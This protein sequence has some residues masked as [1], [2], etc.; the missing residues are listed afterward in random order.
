MKNNMNVRQTVLMGTIFLLLLSACGKNGAVKNRSRSLASGVVF[1]SMNLDQHPTDRVVIKLRSGK[2]LT[3][4]NLVQQQNSG[5]QILQLDRKMNADGMQKTINQLK[6]DPAV[7]DVEPDYI[8]QT[9][10]EPNDT[11][12]SGAFFGN[13]HPLK[14]FYTPNFQP[15]FDYTKG[16]ANLP[17]AWDITEGSQNIVIAVID[18]GKLD[19][20]DLVGHFVNGYDFISS[21][22]DPGDLGAGSFWHGTMVA[23]VVGA[24]GN[25][26]NG[27]VGVNLN[28]RIMPIRVC[29]GN[30]CSTAS[31]A[32]GIRWAVEHG[33]RVVNIS[34]GGIGACPN[35]LQN[36]IDYAYTHNTVV[37]AS[38][39]N[40]GQD[41]DF[42]PANCN[43]VISVG[44]NNWYGE[45]SPYSNYGSR[46]DISAPGDALLM[47]SNPGTQ[48]PVAYQAQEQQGDY[49]I[50]NGTSMSAPVVSGIVSLMLSVD[51]TLTPDLV[52]TIL[53][54]SARAFPN[55]RAGYS[56]GTGFGIVDAKAAVAT[57]LARKNINISCPA[58]IRVG[59]KLIC[60]AMAS[61]S[62]SVTSGRWVATGPNLPAE[63]TQVCGQVNPCISEEADASQVGHVY[64]IYA[65]ATLADGSTIKSN[66]VNVSILAASSSLELNISCPSTITVGQAVT[67]SA[68]MSGGGAVSIVSG[69]WI[70]TGADLPVNGVQICG[71]VNPCITETAVSS[72]A[73][74]TYTIY[75]EATLSD[76]RTILSNPVNVNIIKSF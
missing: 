10:M 8:V 62:I 45:K 17:G 42:F 36:A 59:Q 51:P 58:S 41:I 46:V 21:D 67:C 3:T 60:N 49:A 53:K 66:S 23:S 14:A 13:T 7:L 1:N 6:A 48:T 5:A 22:N 47:A 29:T 39:G 34:L 2:T 56:I 11:Y 35:Y 57:V 12:W 28:S 4:T 43:H 69:R 52:L 63:G 50:A 24:S 71:R 40:N 15:G 75:A 65:I 37:V 19:H 9:T 32:E 33:A 68:S 30:E 16:S 20:P 25:N 64:T 31:I 27:I 76:G 26:H 70:G 73:G 55:P 18:T 74:R 38:A 72:Q 61:T 54:N 44:A